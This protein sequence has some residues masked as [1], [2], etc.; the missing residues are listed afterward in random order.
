MPLPDD[1]PTLNVASCV[2][3][4]VRL[5]ETAWD[6]GDTELDVSVQVVPVQV[7]VPSPGEN[8]DELPLPPDCAPVVRPDPP[9]TCAARDAEKIRTA[10]SLFIR[11]PPHLASWLQG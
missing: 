5:P 6:D 11:A 8:D 3:A 4:K 7:I 2:D 10:K 1:P 9:G